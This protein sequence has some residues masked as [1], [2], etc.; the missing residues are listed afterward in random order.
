MR[1]DIAPLPNTPSWH[2][3]QLKIFKKI[4]LEGE[5]VLNK[6]VFVRDVLEEL[7]NCRLYLKNFFCS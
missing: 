6:S 4:N 3:A 7:D 2:G 5:L 1:G